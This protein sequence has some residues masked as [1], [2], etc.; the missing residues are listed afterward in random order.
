MNPILEKVQTALENFETE[1]GAKF[2]I[3]AHQGDDVDMLTIIKED[4]EEFAILATASESQLLLNVSLFDA[5]QIKEGQTAALHQM[6]L[7]LNMAMPLSSFAK[8]NELYSIFGALSGDSK[9]ETICEEVE[10]LADNIID[11]LEVC[12]NYLNA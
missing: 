8:T 10:V 1:D 7:E 9:P 2:Q 4:M 11:A 12:Q 3:S 5:D 6:M